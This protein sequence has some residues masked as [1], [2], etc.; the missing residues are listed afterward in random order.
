MIVMKSQVGTAP[1]DDDGSVRV[2]RWGTLQTGDG[3]PRAGEAG[4]L[5]LKPSRHMCGE[6]WAVRLDTTQLTVA[7]KSPH[8]PR[9][10]SSH[11]EFRGVGIVSE[12]A[13][14]N[15]RTGFMNAQ[16]SII[17]IA[18]SMGRTGR[19]RLRRCGAGCKEFELE[20][21]WGTRGHRLKVSVKPKG[22]FTDLC[23]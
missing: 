22:G 4:Q 3:C 13:W 14:Q 11:Q 10:M 23:W 6:R 1:I 12:V 18:T 21:D 5:M 9:D 17:L 8:D 16:D 19:N 2:A 15:L 20:R 7:L